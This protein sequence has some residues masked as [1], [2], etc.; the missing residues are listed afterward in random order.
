MSKST[1]SIAVPFYN[2]PNVSHR[3][4]EVPCRLPEA[5]NFWFHLEGFGNA[6]ATALIDDYEE[7]AAA[8]VGEIEVAVGSDRDSQTTINAAAREASI[9]FGR[10][11]SGLHLSPFKAVG[12]TQVLTAIALA[13]EAEVAAYDL[14]ISAHALLP[15]VLVGDA[16][17]WRDPRE[18]DSGRAVLMLRKY[19]EH[20]VEQACKAQTERAEAQAKATP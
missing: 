12:S 3:T 4:I 14:A 6:K 13:Y 1:L 16:M 11:R 8:T 5:F 10:I 17:Y 2:D 15:R 9:I 19:V 18:D 7:T 20:V